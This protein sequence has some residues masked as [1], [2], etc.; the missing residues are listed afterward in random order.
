MRARISILFAMFF[1]FG[2]VGLAMGQQSGSKVVRVLAVSGPETDSLIKNAAEFQRLTGITPAIEQV[3]RPLWGERKVRE[4]LEDS[5]LYDVVMV[6]GGDDLL[7]VKLKGHVLPLDSYLDKNDVAQLS[8]SDFFKKD[9]KLFGIPQYYNFPMLYYRKDMLEN[10]KE[11]ASFKAKYGRVLTPPKNFDELAQVAEFFNR[12]PAMNGFF[13]GGVDW[14]VYLDYTY[15]T[16]GNKTN[17]GDSQ[18]GELTLNTPAGKRVLAAM[19]RMVQ[20]NPKGWETESF[21]DGDQLF[22]QGKIFMYQ[23]WIYITKTLMDK[24]PGKVGMVPVAGD[25]QPGEH[26]GAFVAVIPKAA[27]NPDN[28]GKFI[29][30]MLGAKYQKAQTL[31]TGDLPVRQDVLKDPE[32][33][34]YL[35]GLDQYQ[36]A[37]PYLSY[38]YSTWPNELSA[39]ISEAIWKVFKKQ[40]TPD[41]A[42]D[43]LQNEK[44]KGRK[45]IE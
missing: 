18:T 37:L 4:L 14:S 34:K 25:K 1:F 17:L 30:W 23:N 16:F 36:K 27:A 29:S 10:P 3:A 40:M 22:Q 43:W 45:A 6:G 13:M 33:Q 28:A 20:Y 31:D 15:F 32:V 19:T 2:A 41:Q 11:Q 39:G 12:P 24:M 44:F 7:W 35:P 5:G 42:A 38:Q 9:G 21:F 26:L 8:L